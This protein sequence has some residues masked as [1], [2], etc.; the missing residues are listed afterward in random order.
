MRNPAGQPTPPRP[1]GNRPS[2]QS[3]PS[4]NSIY[5]SSLP[6][7]ERPSGPTASPAPTAKG[8]KQEQM[9]NEIKEKN[10]KVLALEQ[11]LKK[12]REE[13]LNLQVEIR[14]LRDQF[15]ADK[16]R[17][18][19]KAHKDGEKAGEQAMESQL[20]QFME[21]KKLEMQAK[22]D[23][24]H[25]K[26]HKAEAKMKE[27]E[28]T[29]DAERKDLDQERNKLEQ[30]RK[31]KDDE[32]EFYK[33][34]NPRKLEPL[35]N[36]LF[37]EADERN[38]KSKAREE[39][40]E[41]DMES[42]EKKMADM[43][44]DTKRVNEIRRESQFE[45]TSI[46]NELRDRRGLRKDYRSYRG[47]FQSLHNERKAFDTACTDMKKSL[48][49]E[50][51][52]LE[53]G[54]AGLSPPDR[55]LE[56]SWLAHVSNNLPRIK[57]MSTRAREVNQDLYSI[58]REFQTAG[59]RSRLLTNTT[60]FANFNSFAD[61]A[62]ATQRVV[63]NRPM[64]SS[65]E[66]TLQEIIEITKQIETANNSTL[67][68]EL[69]IQRDCLR[70]EHN[71]LGGVATMAQTD[72]KIQV[73]Q[74]AKNDAFVAKYIRVHTAT[75]R[76]E[77]EFVS[78]IVV[79][80]SA[81]A[82]EGRSPNGWDMQ[83]RMEARR[84]MS[85][86]E[87]WEGVLKKEAMLREAFGLSKEDDAKLDHQIDENISFW[88]GK[89][90]DQRSSLL[91]YG[92][93]ARAS[94]KRG[95][96]AEPARSSR[97][98]GRPVSSAS[99][100]RPLKTSVPKP[101][102]SR[103]KILPPQPEIPPPKKRQPKLE[104]ELAKLY[105]ALEEPKVVNMLQDR[106]NA[107]RSQLKLDSS[108]NEAARS[109]LRRRKLKLR[110]VMQQLN[111]GLLQEQMTDAQGNQDPGLYRTM[112]I[113]KKA[114]V[115]TRDS[116][117]KLTEEAGETEETEEIDLKL[118]KFAKTKE[119]KETEETGKTG[120][121]EE[122]K[123]SPQPTYL[124]KMKAR[125]ARSRA[126]HLSQ[127]Q[128][129]LS[130]KVFRF[131]DPPDEAFEG[132]SNETA[133][134]KFAEAGDI[135][136]SGQLNLTP[137]S[138][139]QAIFHLN[140]RRG[141][142]E[143]HGWAA[144]STL[145]ERDWS[146]A[147]QDFGEKNTPLEQSEQS[148][149]LSCGPTLNDGVA[150]ASD[151]A[152]NEH[153]DDA[154]SHMQ[155][156]LASASSPTFISETDFNNVRNNNLLTNTMAESQDE[157]SRLGFEIPAAAMRNALITSKN[158]KGSFWRHNLYQNRENKHPTCHYCTTYEQANT[159]IARFVGEKVVGF[160][161]EWEKASKPGRDGPK[162]CTSLIQIA[163]EDK[164]ALI[165]LAVFRGGDSAVELLPSSL[166]RIL[167]DPGVAKVGV[168]IGG[169]AS[170][171]RECFGLEM[172]GTFELSHLYRLVKYG[173]AEP[174]LVNRKLV[175]LADQ[176][177]E[178]L[179]LPLDKGAVRT[180]S[181]SRRLNAQQCDYAASDAYAGLRL[182]YE[183]EKLRKAMPSKPPRPAFRELQQPIQLGEGVELPTKSK[184]RKTTAETEALQEPEDDGET[185]DVTKALQE[186][187]DAEDDANDEFFDAA[188]D[189]ADPYID[190]Q[191]A[192]SEITHPSLPPLEDPPS[193]PETDYDDF[194][195]PSDPLEPARTTNT[196]TSANPEFDA[197]DAWASTWR[198]QLP[199][200]YNLQV[201]Q[202]NLRAYHLW[203]HQGF[204]LQETAALL[205]KEPPLALSTVVSY[206]AEVLQ[207]E[208]LEFDGARVQ[209]ILARLPVNVRGR[210][211]KL[212]RKA[213]GLKG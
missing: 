50:A 103:S 211:G 13:H 195:L 26:K 116:L 181:W 163:A 143:S 55:I 10:A 84:L 196:R 126:R 108:L 20:E 51:A 140:T 194:S 81:D 114:L 82:A 113:R 105:R 44:A 117:F 177:K 65:K 66:R 87:K 142:H 23:E 184:K 185:N 189:K 33:Q 97:V 7:L 12:L 205:R 69:E 166:C 83:D 119:T 212:Y 52:E 176:V 135:S 129:L 72:R 169:D 128:G 155:E 67:A 31:K 149:V 161:L 96:A 180:S 121:T 92:K 199:A 170:R 54:R 60:R 206:V 36:E 100:P 45:V 21:K 8:A 3:S 53:K 125:K 11:D 42:R 154:K 153:A 134:A 144:Q 46:R 164:I 171:M 197:A 99:K 90:Q 4:T 115:E 168:N 62:N 124:Q 98:R 2:S 152:V 145:D 200:T 173:E 183:L 106:L 123:S 204:E 110:F 178:I 64:N 209:D 58:D 39:A 18:Y 70:A 73:W 132:P 78:A 88:A 35:R 157:V 174:Q 40:L 213:G 75:I 57:A 56:Q 6:S 48:D 59:H 104:D 111:I 190:S 127:V 77:L 112:E 68:E 91:G 101:S 138:A 201:S 93:K 94:A 5:G 210:Y 146:Q 38:A 85:E 175:S 107:T 25:A 193:S 141:L 202:A 187:D 17:I 28:I 95:R 192:E 182:Y 32:V 9:E 19:D 109:G 172:R 24:A 148:I 27:M 156:Y 165:H 130:E 49:R 74:A 120:K 203:H 208:D 29:R 37:K 162:K 159:Q 71:M 89:L 150:N 131:S 118:E 151:E 41:K 15:E 22:M 167:E 188:E 191:G 63:Y 76:E 16:V 133:E 139:K 158:S 34:E 186:P 79:E 1:V 43:E 47:L 136:S 122:P 207:K 147:A 30:E 198:S 86:V 137:S 61:V 179:Y 102:R 160:D 14:E 80:A